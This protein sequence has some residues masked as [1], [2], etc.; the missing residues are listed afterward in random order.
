MTMHFFGDSWTA[1]CELNGYI[2]L[3][4]K[5]SSGYNE[6]FAH[7]L[8]HENKCAHLMKDLAYPAIIGKS[9]NE[10]IV[11]HGITASSQDRMLYEFNNTDFCINIAFSEILFNG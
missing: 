10:S 5:L 7:M 9:L 11:N 3:E 6:R 8:S 4:M 2:S 1:G